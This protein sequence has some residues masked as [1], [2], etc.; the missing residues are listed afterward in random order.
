MPRL[1]RLLTHGDLAGDGGGEVWGRERKGARR[2]G[3]G[4]GGGAGAV[5][6]WAS[7]GVG[8]GVVRERSRRRLVA[9]SPGLRR[10]VVLSVVRERPRTNGSQAHGAGAHQSLIVLIFPSKKNS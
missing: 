8:M 5:G 2:R 1:A 6:F 10:A 9:E 4:E 7:A 3:E